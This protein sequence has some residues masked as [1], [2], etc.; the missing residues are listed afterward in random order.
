VSYTWPISY[1]RYY[2]LYRDFVRLHCFASLGLSFISPL[3]CV[4]V[5][6]LPLNLIELNIVLSWIL[7]SVH[8][9]LFLLN[10][11]FIL[12]ARYYHAV[13]LLRYVKGRILVEFLPPSNLILST[14]PRDQTGWT[15]MSISE[16]ATK[17]VYFNNSLSR[18]NS[19]VRPPRSN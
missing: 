15:Q 13:D 12:C 18:T 17:T 1:G 8:K 16:C 9:C 6:K 7:C 3:C 10:I 11:G 2:D 4:V 14:N 19:A 5:L